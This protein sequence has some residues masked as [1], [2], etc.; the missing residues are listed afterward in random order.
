MT[1]SRRYAPVLLS[2]WRDPDFRTLTV[3]A[4]R[5]YIVLLSDPRRSMVGAVPYTPRAWAATC[6]TT[7][8]EDIDGWLDELTDR[9]YV[10]V[11][12]RTDELLIRT[13]VKH[14]PPAG[15]KQVVAMWRAWERIESE[16]LRRAV[17]AEIGA[18]TWLLDP[19]SRPAAV[20]AMRGRGN[21]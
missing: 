1:V 3:G 6:A 4:Q 7:T 10:I 8:A 11:D 14:D 9:R 18:D 12:T 21:D 15:P 13:V 2:M 19:M 20:D 17:L 5:L 16:H